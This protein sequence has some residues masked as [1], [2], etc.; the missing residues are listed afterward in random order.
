[1][2][3]A[4]LIELSTESLFKVGGLLMLPS[5]LQIA[6]SDEELGRTR[7]AMHSDMA[8]GNARF[9]EEIEQLTGRRVTPRKRGRKQ[10]QMD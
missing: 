5:I 2:K 9:K 6:H 8:L 1:M 3:L 7:S 4:P 10:S